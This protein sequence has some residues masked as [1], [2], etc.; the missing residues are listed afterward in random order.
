MLD[1]E[2]SHRRRIPEAEVEPLPREGMHDVRSIGH[3]GDPRA[4]NRR[5]RPSESGWLEIRPMPVM[6]P[7]QPAATAVDF[8][9]QIL[10]RKRK[11][12]FF[13][14]GALAPHHG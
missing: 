10:R 6:V 2:F 3:Q 9:A 1:H 12:A 7:R 8:R 11:H 13:H 4:T 5:A 14:L